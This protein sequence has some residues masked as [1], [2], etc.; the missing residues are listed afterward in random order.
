MSL[1][2]AERVPSRG[3]VKSYLAI[4]ART[5][6]YDST[7]QFPVEEFEISNATH[8]HFKL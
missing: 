6:S 7:E 5:A 2:G 4:L 1:L 3:S 8:G